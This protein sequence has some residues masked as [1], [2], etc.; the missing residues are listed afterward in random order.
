MLIAAALLL[1]GCGAQSPSVPKPMS[2]QEL[3]SVFTP[4]SPG[5]YR[6]VLTAT[7][8]GT[9]RFT[10]V[11]LPHQLSVEISCRG[12]RSVQAQ[13]AGRDWVEVFCAAGQIGGSTKTFRRPSSLTIVATP[14]ARWSL[15]VEARQG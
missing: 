3:A 13:I 2:V 10:G 15:L 14:N 11:S 6:S 4:S 9:R 5:R 1:V 12:A 7:G 8:H